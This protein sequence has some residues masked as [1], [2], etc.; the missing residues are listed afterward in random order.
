MMVM[1]TR[2]RPTAAFS[3]DT[4]RSADDDIYTL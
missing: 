4:K 3:V 1:M 2:H